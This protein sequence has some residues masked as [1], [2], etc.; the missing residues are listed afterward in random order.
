MP[1]ESSG[2]VMRREASAEVM[3]PSVGRKAGEDHARSQC[4]LRGE[5]M[6]ALL[7]QDEKKRLLR[8]LLVLRN[9]K[10]ICFKFHDASFKSR[11]QG[12]VSSSAQRYYMINVS[13]L[14]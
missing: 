7:R 12:S 14:L 9:G 2:E 6:L 13:F 5:V 8:A 1:A 3:P 11:N 10:I 4:P